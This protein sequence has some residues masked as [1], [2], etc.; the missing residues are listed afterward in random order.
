MKVVKKTDKYSIIEKK[1]GRFGVRANSGQWIN[2][3]EKANI[4]SE[5]GYIKL[6]A[7]A[8]AQEPAAEEA[9]AEEAAEEAPAE[10]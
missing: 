7:P 10:E 6:A 1:S 5:A 2:G 8:V 9:P 4:L 3:V